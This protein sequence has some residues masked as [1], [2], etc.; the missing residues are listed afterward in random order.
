M[1]GE[2]IH[3]V[4]GAFTFQIKASVPHLIDDVADMYADYP[5]DD[6]PGIDD[7][8]L[9]FAAPSLLRRYFAPTAMSWVD[10]N[11]LFEAVPTHRAFALF[12]TSLNWSI[13]F[14][15]VTPMFLHAAVL[16][17]AGRALI[18][19]APSGSGKSTLAAALAWRGWRLLSDEM[20]IFAFEVGRLRANPR[21]VSLKNTAIDVIRGFEPRAHLSRVYRGTPKGDISFMRPPP[22]AVARA[23]EQAIPGLV[24]APEYRANAKANVVRLKKNEAFDLLS[25]NA[26]NYSSMLQTGFD[27]LTGVVERCGAYRLTYSDLETAIDV[28]EGLHNESL[29]PV[30]L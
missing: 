19:P 12:E 28:I 16:E 2:G 29:A 11:P 14:S 26:V 30:S 15:D 4:T 8:R 18:L 20:A 27:L 23:Q 10:G 6:P 21:P 7:A 24:V 25:R 1:R 5:V 22:G 17:R 9:R 13:A 3:L